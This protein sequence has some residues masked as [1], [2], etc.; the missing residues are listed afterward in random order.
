[1]FP[2]IYTFYSLR[3]TNFL[4]KTMFASSYFSFFPKLALI[5]VFPIWFGIRV[6]KIYRIAVLDFANQSSLI[7]LLQQY[8]IRTLPL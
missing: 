7:F 3:I 6:F 8:F 5:P 4:G 1:M 2:L